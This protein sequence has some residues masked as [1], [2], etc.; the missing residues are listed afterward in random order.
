VARQVQLFWGVRP[1]VLED[2]VDH[3]DEVVEVVE[4]ALLRR[5]L[6]EPGDIILILM[7]D[8]IRDRPLTNLVRAHRVQ[9]PPSI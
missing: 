9:A 8:P 2:E 1:L 4:K 3:H 5:R 6:V 7:G